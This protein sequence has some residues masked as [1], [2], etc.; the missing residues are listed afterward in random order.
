MINEKVPTD[1]CP[2]MNLNPCEKSIYMG[3]KPREPAK[4]L[5]PQIMRNTMYPDGMQTGI[6][7]QHL[8]P[9]TRRGVF[10]ENR[11]NILFYRIKHSSPPSL[12]FEN[13]RI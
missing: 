5:I 1:I 6:A 11:P 13:W 8:K 2:R 10:V 9:A 3:D 7:C 4:T 12:L